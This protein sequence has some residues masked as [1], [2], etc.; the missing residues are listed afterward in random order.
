MFFTRSLRPG[1]LK[2]T[3][4]LCLIGVALALSYGSVQSQ[5]GSAANPSSQSPGAP[6]VGNK[7]SSPAENFRKALV[8]SNQ[9]YR[10]P[11]FPNARRDGLQIRDALARHGFEVSFVENTSRTALIEAIRNF[12][13]SLTL[14]SEAFFVYLG[15][16][17]QW[18]DRNFLM[19]V[20]E[21]VG[22]E[23]DIAL[24]GLELSVLLQS[25]DKAKPRASVVVLDAA[26]QRP[27]GPEL[28]LVRPGLADVRAPANTYVVF[29][30][31]PSRL[32]S[33]RIKG[34]SIFVQQLILALPDA[35]SALENMF[36]QVRDSVA[37]KSEGEQVPWDLSSLRETLVLDRS[38]R[39]GADDTQAPDPQQ[40]ELLGMLAA[41]RL[42]WDSVVETGRTRD[43]QAYLARFRNGQFAALAR[44]RIAELE[45]S[46]SEPEESGSGTAS[47][48]TLVDG[49]RFTGRTR[50]GQ[51]HGGGDLQMPNGDVFSGTFQ[52]GTRAGT[53]RLSWVNGDIFVGT[54]KANRPHGF[55]Q[56][57]FANGDQY[58]GH[59]DEGVIQGKGRYQSKDGSVYFG[60]FVKQARTGIGELVTANGERLQGIFKNGLLEGQGESDTY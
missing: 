4:V 49:S 16:G 32:V 22:K 6:N 26:V 44:K 18:R 28:I 40:L 54:F 53:G 36:K 60:E 43:Y 46:R 12:S 51:P 10:F 3:T 23:A 19:P 1:W 56:I 42:F 59:F 47:T 38:I 58:T 15:H 25:L 7:P 9:A 2:T 33:E 50:N 31:A 37:Q 13:Q 27:F 21:T 34:Q 11:G 57:S 20:D 52:D 45:V 39:F 29:S 48:I 55:G 17:V 41:D 24:Y 30:A 14:K 8:I 35:S 5:A